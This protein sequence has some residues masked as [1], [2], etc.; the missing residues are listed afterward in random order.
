[1]RPYTGKRTLDIVCSDPVIQLCLSKRKERYG[2][3]PYEVN[4]RIRSAAYKFLKFCEIGPSN[5]AFSDIVARRLAATPHDGSLER[6][7]KGF[8]EANKNKHNYSS[9]VRSIFKANRIVLFPTGTNSEFKTLHVWR[10][11]KP[12]NPTST[13]AEIIAKDPAIE[14][15]FEAIKAKKRNNGY[16]S[17]RS[18]WMVLHYSVKFLTYLGTDIT[19]HAVSDL[20]KWKQQHPSDFMIED[21]LLRFSNLQPISTHR[22]VGNTVLGIFRENRARLQ[23]SIDFHP[24]SRTKKIS[25]GILRDIFLAQTFENRTLMEYQAYAGQRIHC[26]CKAVRIDQIEHYND[27]FSIVN[28]EF[29]QNKTRMPHIC[30]I[31]RRVA[32]AVIQIAKETGRINPFPNYSYLWKQITNYAR[33][34]HG[35]K[36]TSHYL[37]KRFHTI[38]Q[39]TPMPVNDW[40]F[41]M[42]D[43]LEVGYGASAYTLEDWSELI[44]EYGRCLAP[45]LSLTDLRNP[46][47]DNR[48]FDEPLLHET[49]DGLRKVIQRQDSLIRQLQLSSRNP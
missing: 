23:M 6:A 4:T 22:H 29:W 32:E 2:R 12:R 21:K 16:I 44:R 17:R 48:S 37:R 9:H 26:L 1:M 39:K 36:L 40:D 19:D 25:D 11:R 7:L 27:D 28:I 35:V 31:P 20:V 47:M 45:Y 5:H 3:I 10:P 38:A 8:Y 33:S 34:K 46:T 13:F 18:I 15:Y 30:L 41:L 24:V 42:G 43:K 14:Q 49:I